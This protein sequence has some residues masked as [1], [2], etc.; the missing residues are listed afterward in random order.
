MIGRIRRKAAVMVDA[1]RLFFMLACLT[2]WL[3]GLRIRKR[4]KHYFTGK[5]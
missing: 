1:F 2:F 5:R 3:A 4:S